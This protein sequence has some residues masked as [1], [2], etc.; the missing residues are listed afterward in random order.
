LRV[1]WFATSGSFSESVTGEAKPDTVWH[2]DT[3]LPAPG[4]TIDVY[5]VGREER[6]GT[7]FAHRAFIL[8]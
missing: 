2:L 7:D 6:G 1:S 5:I 4:A 3:H 8:R